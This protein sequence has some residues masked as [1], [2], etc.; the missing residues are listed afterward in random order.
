MT[1]L[2]QEAYISGLFSKDNLDLRTLRQKNETA[3]RS[4]LQDFAYPFMISNLLSKKT[5]HIK[6]VYNNYEP[7]N[8]TRPFEV[9]VNS[10]LF[11]APKIEI[12]LVISST[13]NIP[14][15]L[16]QQRKRKS[17]LEVGESKQRRKSN[18]R[19][20]SSSMST[21]NYNFT[22]TYAPMYSPSAA[23]WTPDVGVVKRESEVGLQP[24]NMYAIIND[25]FQEFW[26]MEFSEP[27]V[28]AGRLISAIS[29]LIKFTYMC[30][31]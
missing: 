18:K 26:L 15:P 5:V 10:L 2:R 30:L 22:N 27:T 8:T 31:S 6:D 14:I 29:T 23:G 7:S 19:E 1:D 9:D 3:I 12:P 28:A 11:A 24:R 17:A 13:S 25:I 16:Q 20:D 4:G 21:M